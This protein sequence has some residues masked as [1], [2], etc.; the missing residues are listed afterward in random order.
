M[1]R[2]KEYV[3]RSNSGAGMIVLILSLLCVLGIGRAE[4]D[5]FWSW[6]T[7][8]WTSANGD[9]DLTANNGARA[10]A[11][12]TVASDPLADIVFHYA[13]EYDR[14]YVLEV[15]GY[16]SREGRLIPWNSR[17]GVNPAI[18]VGFEADTRRRNAA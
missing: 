6:R 17:T 7:N 9:A 11:F 12:G 10:L 5:W 1:A 3:L 15:N 8:L 13:G 16:G 18:A 2:I 14:V 4:N